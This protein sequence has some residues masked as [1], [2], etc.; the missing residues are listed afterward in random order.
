MTYPRGVL[1][2]VIREPRGVYNGWF[3]Q[4]EEDPEGILILY[5]ND[6]DDPKSASYDDF[7]VTPDE[8]DRYIGGW[9]IEWLERSRTRPP[10]VPAPSAAAPMVGTAAGAQLVACPQCG[11][12]NCVAACGTCGRRFV[13][14][15]AH[16]AGRPRRREDGPLRRCPEPLPVRGCDFCVSKSEGLPA[17]KAVE[18]GLQMRLC[19]SC[20][21]CM[22]PSYQADI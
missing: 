19:A 10:I 11:A 22:V 7:A 2:R 9:D 13:L 17:G 1:G 18:M 20:H 21:H 12:L 4:L 3:V 15:S 14:T 8:I 5:I 16:I 6:P